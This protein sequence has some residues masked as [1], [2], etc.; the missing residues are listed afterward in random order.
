MIP[1]QKNELR[2]MSSFNAIATICF[3][4][5]NG[6]GFL[7]VGFLWDALADG[8][9]IREEWPWLIFA[10]LGLLFFAGGGGWSLWRRKAD[11]DYIW[12]RAGEG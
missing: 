1:I 12:K 5:A 8:Q 2:M 10:L 7:G 6:I 11:F 9:I 4:M 3:S